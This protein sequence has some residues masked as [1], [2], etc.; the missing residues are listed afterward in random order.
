MSL[1][2]ISAL[3]AKLDTPSDKAAEKVIRRLIP[4][5]AAAV[6]SLL[7]ATSGH[8]PRIRKWSLQALGAI[9]NPRAAPALIKAL[10]DPQM[11]VRLHALRG[12]GRMKFKP[13]STHIVKLLRDE[14]GGIRVN[15]IQALLTIGKLPRGAAVVKSLAD[16]Q[17]YVRQ[18]AC[19]ACEKFQLISAKKK[20]AQ[21]AAKDPK[22]AVRT[23]AELALVSF[24]K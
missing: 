24:K 12:L 2:V 17:W 21:L 1:K 10:K 13:A 23:A 18:K 14:S 22:K 6:P 11:T 8:N 19:L 16:E 4:F 7:L 20:I 3:I 5:R 9:G 15:A